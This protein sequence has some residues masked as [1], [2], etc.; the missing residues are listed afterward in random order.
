MSGNLLLSPFPAQ[1]TERGLTAYPDGITNFDAGAFPPPGVYLDYTFLY[2]LPSSRIN[3]MADGR[4]MLR[5]F[6]QPAAPHMATEPQRN[7][8]PTTA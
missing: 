5:A 8:H 1:A 2:D 7:P 4:K 6:N 3:P